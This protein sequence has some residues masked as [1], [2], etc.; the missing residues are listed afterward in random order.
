MGAGVL[1][2]VI[3]VQRDEKQISRRVIYND[4]ERSRKRGRDLLG[5]FVKTTSLFHCLFSP[6][7]CVGFTHTP[8]L[9][10]TSFFSLS[11]LLISLVLESSVSFFKKFFFNSLFFLSFLGRRAACD[12]SSFI[13]RFR[14]T[15]GKKKTTQEAATAAAYEPTEPRSHSDVTFVQR[16]LARL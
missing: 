1:H 3:L 11:L 9:H 8:G 2:A 4:S 10:L 14:V 12:A 5:E 15:I 13:D 7:V 16:R 6:G